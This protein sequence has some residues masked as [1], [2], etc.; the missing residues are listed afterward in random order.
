M[1]YQ[2]FENG[3][4]TMIKCSKC[5]E[6]YHNHY[7]LTNCPKCEPFDLTTANCNTCTRMVKGSTCDV[8]EP[9]GENPEQYYIPN[10]KGNAPMGL[11]DFLEGANPLQN[12]PEKE[13]LFTQLN[14]SGLP[15][16]PI[17]FNNDPFIQGIEVTIWNEAVKR[18]LSTEAASKANI[19]NILATADAVVLGYR[20][21]LPEEDNTEVGN[22]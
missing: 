22:E 20:E 5:G 3:A 12:T 14:G 10:Q 11:E 21:R 16:R 9:C 15:T 7:G 17:T 8:Q 4:E 1:L 19:K 6:L 2:H 13:E 18:I